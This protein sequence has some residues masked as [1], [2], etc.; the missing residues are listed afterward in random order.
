[1]HS[2]RNSRKKKINYKIIN[3]T[4]SLLK[5]LIDFSSQFLINNRWK[6]K[7]YISYIRNFQK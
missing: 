3:F 2:F 1:M 7:K 4:T 5:Q 6:Q